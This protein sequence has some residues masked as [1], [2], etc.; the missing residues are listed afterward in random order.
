[1]IRSLIYLRN[2]IWLNESYRPSYMRATPFFGGLVMSVVNEKLK[3]KKVK[4]SQIVVHSG[5]IAIFT[6]TFWAQFYGTVF[7]ER[8]RP[9]YPLEHALYSII[10]HSTWPVAGIW[11]TMSYFTSGY[12]ILN[13]VFNNRIFTIMGKLTYSVSLVNITFLLLS[14]SSQKLPIHMTSKYL[15]DSWLSDAFMCFLISIILYLV[16]EE[17]FR[18][19][20]GKLFYQR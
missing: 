4:F 11:I 18:K 20:T 7:Y 1:M 17:P 16:V 3:E 19:L 8:N 6:L 13:N 5:I 10:T 12:G 14:Q 15:F 9:Y 2:V